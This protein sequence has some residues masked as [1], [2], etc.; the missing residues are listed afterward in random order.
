MSVKITYLIGAG[1]SKNFIPINSS[2]K[3]EG[4][5]RKTNGILDDMAEVYRQKKLSRYEPFFGNIIGLAKHFGTPD[6]FA[7]Y[8]LEKNDLENYEAIKRMLVNYFKIKQEFGHPAS[9]TKID[10]RVIPFLS[11]ISNKN[12]I[13]DNVKIITWNY[14]CQFQMA[15]KLLKPINSDKAVIDGFTEWPNNEN[16]NDNIFITHLNG[17]VPFSEDRTELDYDNNTAYIK[18]SWEEESLKS[19]LLLETLLKNIQG[20]KILVVIG[21]SF[22]FFNR[23]ID[24]AIFGILKQSV[25][26]IYYQNADD[27][28]DKLYTQFNLRT[29]DDS[30]Y[31]GSSFMPVEIKKVNSLDNYFIPYEL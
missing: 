18:F 2:I 5:E 14:D 6:L 31:E 9:I 30:Y 16:I 3:K 1:A 4:S 27:D 10:P 12:K 17:Y 26:R 28:Y 24:K 7:K 20:T 19:S 13:A 29:I 8:S 23:I 11:T 25:T 21:Y 15:A 22:P